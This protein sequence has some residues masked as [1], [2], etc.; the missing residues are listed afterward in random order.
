M[1]IVI[2]DEFEDDIFPTQINEKSETEPDRGVSTQTAP[3]T[4]SFSQKD[5]KIEKKINIHTLLQ[6]EACGCCIKTCNKTVT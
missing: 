6:E 1:Y 5:D 3:T 4:S 2:T